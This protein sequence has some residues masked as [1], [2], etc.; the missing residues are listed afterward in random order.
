MSTGSTSPIM[1]EALGQTT[2]P[3]IFDISKRDQIKPRLP[4]LVP[5]MYI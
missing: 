1:I 4:K 5:H 3:A 2:I